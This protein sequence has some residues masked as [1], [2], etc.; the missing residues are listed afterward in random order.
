[1][2]GKEL[3][4]KEA[5]RIERI[6]NKLNNVNVITEKMIYRNKNVIKTMSGKTYNVSREDWHK[7]DIG[8]KY[9]G[10]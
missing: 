1:M 3:D 9:E 7:Y 8:D 6:R 10:N 2:I 4:E 5:E